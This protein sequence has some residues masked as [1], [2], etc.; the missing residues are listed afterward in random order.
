MEELDRWNKTYPT[1]SLYSYVIM[2]NHLHIMV[3]IS[4]DEFGRPQVAPTVDRMIKQFKGAVTKKIGTSIWQ[5]SYMEHVIR[6]KDDYLIKSNYIYENPI[7][8]QH[9]ELYTEN[10]PAADSNHNY[11]TANKA[12]RFLTPWCFR[13]VNIYEIFGFQT[14]LQNVKILTRYFP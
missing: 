14:D 8:W 6:N 7:R 11:I 10:P 4:A 5:K 9:D 1:V 2:P 3:V 13:F 12:P